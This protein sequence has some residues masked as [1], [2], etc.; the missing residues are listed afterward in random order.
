VVDD[1]PEARLV[2][3]DLLHAL[4]VGSAQ[5]QGVRSAAG[6]GEALSLIRLAS[7]AGES[8]DLMLLDWAMTEM[9]G[10]EVL[11]ALQESDIPRPPLTV[12]V[13]AYDSEVMHEV[14][15]RF[16]AQHF[17]PKPILPDSLRSLLNLLTG[18]T[19]LDRR[20]SHVDPVEVDL[21]GMRVLLVEDNPIN[22]QLALELMES[23]GVTVT[24]ANDGQEALNK[25]D[26]VAPDYFHVVLMDLQMPVMD[27]YEATRRLRA[28]PR[29]FTLPLVAMTAHAMVEER[30]RCQALGMNGHLSKPI[31]TQEFYAT[32][33]RYYIPLPDSEVDSVVTIPV[34]KGDEVLLPLPTLSGLDTTAGLRHCGGNLKLYRTM[35]GMFAS[36]YADFGSTLSFYIDEAHWETA[37]RLAHTLRGLAGTVGATELVLAATQLETACDALQADAAVAAQ[38]ALLPLL[39]PLVKALQDFF[40][41]ENLEQAELLPGLST[42][43]S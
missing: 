22:Q 1:R 17:L 31:E 40:A 28:N 32:L 11:Q 12:I 9:N 30:I 27:G 20:N 29:Y 19:V 10:A 5:G 41:A 2:L 35:L 39:D 8:Y 24:L 38:S 4:G 13:S 43:S 25:L 33:G 23:H 16:G 37:A 26:A 6:G 36:D 7:E 21:S 34:V 15:D 42:P 14:A 18:N 3:T